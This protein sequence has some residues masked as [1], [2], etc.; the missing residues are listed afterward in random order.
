MIENIEFINFNF[1][2]G[3]SIILN[4]SDINKIYISNIDNQANEIPY[5]DTI[6]NN[7][8]FANF[9]ICKFINFEKDN[10]NMFINK[11]IVDIKLVFKNK[12]YICFSP[13]SDA[14]PFSQN[15]CNN[16]QQCYFKNEELC[17]LISNYKFKYIDSLFS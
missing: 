8:L 3:N 11:N 5:E 1:S 4:K 13:V 7:K 16:Y 6:I 14:D 2:N 9:F 10:M 15:Y 12:K 17:I